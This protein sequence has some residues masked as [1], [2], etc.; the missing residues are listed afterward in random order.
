MSVVAWKLVALM[1]KYGIRPL[2]I[3]CEA[4]RLGYPM[5][6]NVIY[7][8]AIEDGPQRIDRATLAAIVAAM[9]S[10]SDADVGV[11]DVLVFEES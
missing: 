4:I 1:K 8:V 2:D 6:K 5:G 10:L 11:G 7:R 9:R 3:E